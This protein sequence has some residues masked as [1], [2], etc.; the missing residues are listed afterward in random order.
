[1]NINK[2]FFTFLG[3]GLSGFA[4][5]GCDNLRNTFGLDHYQPDEFNISDNPPLSIPKDY[6]LRPPVQGSG[7]SE[8]AAAAPSSNEKVQ[9]L[10]VGQS[11]GGAVSSSKDPAARSLLAQAADGQTV[12]P[13]IR[14]TVNKEA[15]LD[16]SASAPLTKK[17]EGWKK[18]AATNIA[19]IHEEKQTSTQ[20]NEPSPHQ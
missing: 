18:E 11:K 19:S 15:P 17:I 6:K 2:K 8:S 4:L 20:E 3:L 16:T 1:M 9:D 7:N 10:L 14:E 5:S 12:D 13:S